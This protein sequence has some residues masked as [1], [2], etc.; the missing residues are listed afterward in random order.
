MNF[1]LHKITDSVPTIPPYALLALPRNWQSLSLPMQAGKY[2]VN[3]LSGLRVL[4]STDTMEDGSKFLHISCSYPDR[5]PSWDDL[6]TVKDIFIGED[7]EAFQVLPKAKDYVNLH[8]Y[9]LHLW[10]EDNAA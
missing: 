7:R 4:A 6:K 5:I 8:P 1:G 2:F 10:A 9:C 3:S